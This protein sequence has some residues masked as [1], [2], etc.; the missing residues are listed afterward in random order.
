MLRTV[1]SR[2]WRWL[3][4][5]PFAA[6]AGLALVPSVPAAR[7]TAASA[8]TPVCSTSNLR[9]DKIGEQGFTSHRAWALSAWSGIRVASRYAVRRWPS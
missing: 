6:L 7:P 5:A 2:K 4:L 1:V 9:V 3:G 8:A